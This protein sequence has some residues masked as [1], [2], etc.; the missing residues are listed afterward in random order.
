LK[1]CTIFCE[2]R[3]LLKGHIHGFFKQVPG[4]FIKCR[5]GSPM[6]WDYFR[7]WIAMAAAHVKAAAAI[8]MSNGFTGDFSDFGI[9]IP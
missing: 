8:I 3:E 7:P 9:V 5:A 2:R 4:Y 1:V 6:H